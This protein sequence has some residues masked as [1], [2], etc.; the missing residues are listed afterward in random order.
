MC[1]PLQIGRTKE[2][3]IFD[4]G[5][6][7]IARDFIIT[8]LAEDD[9]MLQKIKVPHGSNSYNGYTNVYQKNRGEQD[10]IK[11][12]QDY[13]RTRIRG[14]PP[15]RSPFFMPKRLPLYV[16]PEAIWEAFQQKDE[17]TI[18]RKFPG[19]LQPLN[20]KNYTVRIHNI[21]HIYIVTHNSLWNK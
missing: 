4:F 8:G 10:I 17:L 13:N 15:I 7:K 16:V 19:A 21:K 18:K 6:F 3:C 14:A 1:T 2:L 9:E 20:F 5:T 12:R 11:I